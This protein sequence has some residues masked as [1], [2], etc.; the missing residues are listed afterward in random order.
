MNM[1]SYEIKQSIYA[2]PLVMQDRLLMIQKIMKKFAAV[3]AAV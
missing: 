1:F 3:A 2:L